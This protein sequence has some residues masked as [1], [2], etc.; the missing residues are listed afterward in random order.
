MSIDA[1]LIRR[2]YNDDLGSLASLKALQESLGDIT[3]RLDTYNTYLPKQARWQ[4]ELLVSD[5]AH[6]PE[7]G[8]AAANFLVLTQ[9]LDKTSN[10]LDRM[11]QLAAAAR[12]VALGDLNN[13]RTA[14]ESF[15]RQERAQVFDQLTQQRVAAV[16]DLHSERLAATADLRGER[17]IVLDSLHS[18]EV[19][20]MHDLNVLSQQTLNDVDQ[21]SRRLVDHLFWRAVELILGALLVAFLIAWALLRR[22]TSRTPPH[23]GNYERA[24]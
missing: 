9:A 15:L 7:F 3:A 16:A 10:N 14:A 2:T 8:T 12:Q 6:G 23:R 20:A 19:A 11:P 5:L 17:Q 21:R 18:E 24:A 1:D 22:F 4:A 13:Q